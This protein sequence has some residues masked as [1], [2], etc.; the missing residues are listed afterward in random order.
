MFQQ[1]DIITT[2]MNFVQV[3]KALF[4]MNNSMIKITDTNPRTNHP[5]TYSIQRSYLISKTKQKFGCKNFGKHYF[6]HVY[7]I[8]IVVFL[9]VTFHIGR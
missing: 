8:S 6:T 1:K 4:Q 3:S 7:T 5:T 9:N 2:S